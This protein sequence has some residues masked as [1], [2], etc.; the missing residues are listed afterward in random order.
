MALENAREALRRFGDYADCA[1][2]AGNIAFERKYMREAG[3]FYR[4]AY[5]LNDARGLIGLQ[6]VAKQARGGGENEP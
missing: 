3:E 4:K 5:S 1:L 6:N 2:L